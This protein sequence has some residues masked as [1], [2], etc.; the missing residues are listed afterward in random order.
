MSTM[1][2]LPDWDITRA[3]IMGNQI[4][5]LDIFAGS[6][7]SIITGLFYLPFD[8][9]LHVVVSSAS[10]DT[11]IMVPWS[12]VLNFTKNIQLYKFTNGGA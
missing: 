2:P 11:T 10:D 7:F 3:T 5:F 1:I 12:S 8:R 6:R 9:N 4:L